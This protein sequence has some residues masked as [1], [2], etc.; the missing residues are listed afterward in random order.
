MIDLVHVI[1]PACG[2]AN[3]VPRARLRDRPKCGH[4]RAALFQGKPIDLDEAGFARHTREGDLPVLVDFW[5]SWCAP[6]KAMAPQFA[7]AAAELEPVVRLAKVDT[8]SAAT[9]AAELGIRSI[10]TLILIQRGR[11]LA[12]QSG[13][14]SAREI[15]TWVRR[16]VSV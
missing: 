1:C 13:V 5:A 12:R 3:R 16:Y 15:A 14:M 8:D 7:A 4:C 2:A 10:P 11:E 9:V 6:C